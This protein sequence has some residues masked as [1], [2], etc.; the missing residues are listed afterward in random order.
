VLGQERLEQHH[1]LIMT[2]GKRFAYFYAGDCYQLKYIFLELKEILHKLLFFYTFLTATVER[3]RYTTFIIKDH[4]SSIC[5]AGAVP[6]HFSFLFF[7]QLSR[8]VGL[9]YPARTCQPTYPPSRA[10]P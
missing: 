7:L 8:T 10:D 4:P 3:H 6:Q 1:Q 2:K 9:P 5:F